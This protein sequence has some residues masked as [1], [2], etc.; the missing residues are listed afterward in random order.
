MTYR[1]LMMIY[2]CMRLDFRVHTKDSS[3][4][5]Y[6]WHDDFETLSSV[7]DLYLTPNDVPFIEQVLSVKI[8]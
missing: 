6:Y 1:D 2:V 8:S 5:P 3:C 4:H 7:K